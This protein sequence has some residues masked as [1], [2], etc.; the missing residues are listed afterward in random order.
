VGIQEFWNEE[1]IL[2][3][4]LARTLPILNHDCDCLVYWNRN[5]D[6]TI[7]ITSITHD[8]EEVIDLID[9]SDL[10]RVQQELEYWLNRVA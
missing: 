6:G 1:M 5:H 3:Y 8:G 2:P 9:Q 4:P 10:W 7:E